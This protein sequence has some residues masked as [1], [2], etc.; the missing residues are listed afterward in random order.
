MRSWIERLVC[1]SAVLAVSGYSATMAQDVG[2]VASGNWNTGSTWTTGT[3]PGASN[4]VYIGS[5]YPSLAV[6]TA[7]VT[8]TQAQSANN[9]YLGNGNGTSGT[10]DLG[11]NALTITGSLAIGQS[12]GAGTLNEGGGSFTAQN[13]YVY[14]SGNSLTFGA[15]DAVSYLQL[16]S[17]SSATTAAGNVTG[18]V[19]VLTGSSLNLGANLSLTGNLNVQDSGSMLNAQGHAITASNLYLGWNGSSPVSVTNLGLV[20]ATNLYIANGTAVTLNSSNLGNATVVAGSSLT[21][22][23]DTTLSGNVTVQ[24]SGS[25]LDMGGHSLTAS[26]LYLG[27][28][29]SSPV[30]V[31]NTGILNLTNLDMGNG[32]ALTLHGGDTITNA[33]VF[34]GSTLNLGANATFSG[35]VT[36]QD[37]GS[38]LDMAGHSLTASTLYLGWNGSSP[39]TVTNTGILNLTNLDMGNGTALTLHGGDTITN[40]N[41]FA[42]STLNLGANATFSGNVTVQ[43]SGST[44]DMAGHSLTASTLYLGWN[45]SSPVTVTNTGILN[46]TNLDMGNG[47]ALTLHGGD[48][49]T[50]A[51]VFAG[52]T[53]NLASDTTFSGANVSAGSTLTLGTDTTFSG[54]VSVQDAGSTLDMAGHSLTAGS[55]LLGWNGSSPVTVTNAGNLN[56]TN[57]DL[58]N[59]TALT[60]HGGDTITNANVFAGSTLNLGANATFS[61]NVTV[62]DSGSTLDMAG[63]S[64]TAS[65]LYLGWNGSSPVTVTNTGI[66]NLINLDMGNGTALT[67]HGGDTITNANV[68]AGSTLNLGAN[69]TFSG[70]VTVQDSG[71]TLDMAGHSLTASTLYLGWNGS[72][73]SS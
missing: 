19:N 35:N 15:N 36:V 1:M 5:T 71:S 14:G 3:P 62:Q 57:L 24:D 51:N 16:N 17:G 40:A 54:N 13:A 41:V 67:L 64:L 7:T 28:N 21:L 18:K 31:T 32:T 48:T 70:N 37:S 11:G 27:W 43:D 8:L 42:G 22:G 50:N 56:L 20:T 61:G 63:H 39:V 68:F 69:A 55:L 34:A 73:P 23:A 26:T 12:G 6:A 25:T 45:G 30:T 60:L 10:L 9:V 38:T 53:L 44:L 58:G 47:T 66:L 29:G 49:I 33:N 59:G 72:S 52:S 4:N 46:L 65:T 2:A